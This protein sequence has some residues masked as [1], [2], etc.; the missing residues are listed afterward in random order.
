M[1]FIHICNRKHFFATSNRRDEFM[2]Y[3]RVFHNF[4]ISE[5]DI[6]FC[7]DVM[8]MLCRTLF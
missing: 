5:L 3:S 8:F 1:L 6:T 4:I 2:Y 7:Y